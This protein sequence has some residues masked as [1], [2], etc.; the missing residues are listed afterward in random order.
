M[1]FKNIKGQSEAINIIKKTIENNRIPQS[2]LFYG[3]PG[4]GKYLTA[5]TF[6]KVINCS[7]LRL[8]ACHRCI[9]CRRISN[10]NHPDVIIINSDGKKTSI[11]ID[12]IRKLQSNINLKCYEAERKICIIRDAEK[13]TPEA[14]N[15]LL[16]SLEDPPL[17]TLIILVVANLE[18]IFPTIISRSQ[19]VRF[20][21]LSNE[22]IKQIVTEKINFNSKELDYFVGLSEGS[23][24]KIFNFFNKN[25][26]RQRRKLIH[27]MGEKKKEL[28]FYIPKYDSR[29]D[30]VNILDIM[31]SWYKDMFLIK[32]GAEK[33]IINKDKLQTLY[34]NSDNIEL[35][36]IVRIIES[37]IETKKDIV[38]NANIKL[39]IQNNMLKICELEGVI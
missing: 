7:N 37:I 5:L 22:I 26:L 3:P 29:Q 12:D 34:K 13:M 17:G 28:M 4:V 32:T 36:K 14:E 31:V 6:A 2:F 18:N 10:S 1:S 16:K 19:I 38:N 21:P 20:K 9:N 8:E 39:A 23:L 15:S 25:L 11:K 30:A 27:L 35:D 33:L 24:E